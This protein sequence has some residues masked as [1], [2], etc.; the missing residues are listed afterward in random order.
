MLGANFNFPNIRAIR[1]RED[2]RQIADLIELCFSP[3]IDPE[4][5]DYIRNIRQTAGNFSGLIPEQTTPETSTLP[6][7]GYVCVDNQRIIGNLTSSCCVTAKR[8]TTSW[9]T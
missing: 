2:L 1:L 4:G 5:R 3:H 7:H 8:A 9:Q 6:F